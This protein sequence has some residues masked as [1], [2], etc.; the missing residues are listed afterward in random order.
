MHVYN[1][2]IL[3][4][5]NQSP[6]YIGYESALQIYKDVIQKH[7]ITSSFDRRSFSNSG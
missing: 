7:E 2:H 1:N 5:Y 3:L 4:H 6:T